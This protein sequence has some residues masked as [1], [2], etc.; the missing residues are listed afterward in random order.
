MSQSNT[1]IRAFLQ[2]PILW[3]GIA[4][5][6]F[7]A[8]VSAEV[9][10][11]EYI[12]DYFTGHPVEYAAAVMFFVGLAALAIKTLM[13][14]AQ[15]RRLDEPLL[16]PV[17][18]GGQ[19]AADCC[20]LAARLDRLPPGQQT[21]YL[22][23]RLHDALEFVRR[24]GSADGL[25]EE[26]RYLADMDAARLHASYGLVRVI[27][28]AIPVLGFLGTVIGITMAIGK[29]SPAALETSL[30]EVM[31][32]LSVAFY[33][34]TQALGLSIVLMFAQ[35][36]TDRK[37]NALLSEV[38][39][40]AE[41]E[42]IGRF[43]RALRQGDGQ[44]GAVRQMLEAVIA[45][46]EKLVVRQAEIW[47]SSVAAAA[48]RWQT[49]AET[50]GRQLE[51]ALATSLDRSLEK[52]AMTLVDNETRLADTNRENWRRIQDTLVDNTQSLA[53]LNRAVREEAELIGQAVDAAS[54]V[55]SLE[56]AL[57]RNLQ[58]LAGSR[59]FEETV[60]SLAAAIHLLNNRLGA[61]AAGTRI[62]QLESSRKTEQAA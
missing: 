16:G 33:T 50:S 51:S 4:S 29:L 12:E 45:G 57:N 37:E 31:K 43:E 21:D 23:G 59:N 27:I 25:D 20:T 13:T 15:L 10:R 47:Q 58:A 54:R 34:T 49:M 35:F 61:P 22:V 60:M 36:L 6:G 41:A 24:S 8:L 40:Q 38:D 62:V 5:V 39:K 30:P 55:T 7:Y 26:L 2:S 14:G 11:G 42:M 9:L 19:P 32:S 48:Q 44:L 18:E 3:G 1:P 53:E 52:H 28:W 46:T 17:R 56:E